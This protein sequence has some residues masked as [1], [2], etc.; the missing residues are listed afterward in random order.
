[1]Q[2]QLHYVPLK[3]LSTPLISVFPCHSIYTSPI[4]HFQP[5]PPPTEPISKPL[6]PCHPRKPLPSPTLRK[7]EGNYANYSFAKLELLAVKWAVTEKLNDYLLG[8]DFN[9]ITAKNPLSY[10]QT[11]AKLGATK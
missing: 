5:P 1:M 4:S 6:I 2:L 8:L 10:I 3:S 11:S 9:I 7:A